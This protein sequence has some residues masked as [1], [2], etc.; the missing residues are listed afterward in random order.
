VEI[1]NI[2]A[3]RLDDQRQLADVLQSLESRGSSPALPL[4]D[5]DPRP[6]QDRLVTLQND[7]QSIIHAADCAK[8]DD[9][10]RAIF[11]ATAAKEEVELQIRAQQELMRTQMDAFTSEYRELEAILHSHQERGQSQ[12]SYLNERFG[13]ARQDLTETFQRTCQKFE[14]EIKERRSALAREKREMALEY[15]EKSQTQGDALMMFE[16][17][18]TDA[19]ISFRADCEA[20]IDVW[21]ERHET[22][23]EAHEKLKRE[24]QKNSII[25]RQQDIERIESLQL[26]LQGKKSQFLDLLDA[27]SRAKAV[28]KERHKSRGGLLPV[29]VSTA[30][31]HAGMP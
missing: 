28:P 14:H 30:C 29:T 22:I 2:R 12:R 16:S 24:C 26:L 4:A 3:A 18:S 11:R 21:N 23:V 1:A 20:R 17:F 27:L 6:L 10:E 19:F 15:Q 31:V 25:S 13:L 7:T 8:N 9:I 5:L